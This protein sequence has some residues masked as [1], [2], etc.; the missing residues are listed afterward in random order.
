M[1]IWPAGEPFYF[2]ND[3]EVCRRIAHVPDRQ[4]RK[5]TAAKSTQSIS[6][7]LCVLCIRG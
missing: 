1:T 5:V 2:Q 3:F 7:T 6:T 4:T